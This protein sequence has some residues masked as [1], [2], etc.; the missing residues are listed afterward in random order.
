MGVKSLAAAVAR[1]VQWRINAETRAMRGT[2]QGGRFVSGSKSYPIAQ[3]VDCDTGEG[4]RAWAQLSQS[5]K[6]VVVGS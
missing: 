3:A 4:K 5:G 6:A 1:A 2:I